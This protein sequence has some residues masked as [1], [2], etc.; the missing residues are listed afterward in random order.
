MLSCRSDGQQLHFEQ[1][2][3]VRRNHAAGA[4]GAVAERRGDH[5]HAGAADLHALHAFVPALDDLATGQVEAERVAAVLARIDLL[6][7]GA[8]LVEPAGV[9]HGDALAGLGLG[10]VAGHEVLVLQARGRAGQVQ[11]DRLVAAGDGQQLDLEHQRCVGRDHAAGAAFAIAEGGRNHQHARAADLHALHAFVPAA[12]DHAAVEFELERVVA[13][14]ARVELGALLPAVAVL[15]VEPA[16]VVDG[17]VLA[18][19]GGGAVAD[20]LVFV[21]QAAGVDVHGNPFGGFG[22]DSLAGIMPRQVFTPSASRAGR[23]AACRRRPSV[24]AAVRTAWAGSRS[25]SAAAPF[26]L[27]SFSPLAP[28]TRGVSR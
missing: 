1:Q 17:D 8:V 5:Q 23:S 21:L 10:A 4:A 13:V 28:S 6:A 3:R 27:D 26:C 18:G 9:V 15:D 16:G 12:D 24:A 7:L 19:G 2:R 14:L 25:S 20:D 11:G 22:L